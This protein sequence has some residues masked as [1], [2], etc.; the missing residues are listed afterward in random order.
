MYLSLIIG[1]EN[2]PLANNYAIDCLIH[3][4][5]WQVTV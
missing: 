3:Y 4:V 5:A 2:T 1:N